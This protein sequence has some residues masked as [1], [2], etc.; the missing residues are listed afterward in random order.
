M[1]GT[2]AGIDGASDLESL[3][4]QDIAVVVEHGDPGDFRLR[5]QV[6]RPDRDVD[7]RPIIPALGK[8]V[9]PAR[10]THLDPG[11]IYV[12]A[13]SEI[14]AHIEWAHIQAETVK[15]I[16]KALLI[17]LAPVLDPLLIG[18]FQR[19]KSKQILNMER[20]AG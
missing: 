19:D 16:S 20:I 7:G 11:P 12:T 1:L 14:A 3:I 6:G 2:L 17:S 5:R 13:S 8:M 9:S 15:D 4:E 18:L 10:R